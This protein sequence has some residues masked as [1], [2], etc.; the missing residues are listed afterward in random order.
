MQL[1]IYCKSMIQAILL[2][3]RKNVSIVLYSK[4][5]E[6][7]YKARRKDSQPC[8]LCL[9]Y[10]HGADRKYRNH[11]YFSSLNALINCV[12]AQFAFFVEFVK[13]V[14]KMAKRGK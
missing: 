10:A 8:T 3:F 6:H 5:T 11:V 13:K 1:R 9:S 7:I 14:T 12:L 4:C 2:L